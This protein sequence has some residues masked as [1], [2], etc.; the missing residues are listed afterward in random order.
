MSVAVTFKRSTFTGVNVQRFNIH[1]HTALIRKHQFLL[2]V[3]IGPDWPSPDSQSKS[4]WLVV[5]KLLPQ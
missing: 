4:H 2:V 5:L 1:C 3:E